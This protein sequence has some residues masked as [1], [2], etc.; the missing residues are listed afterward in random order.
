MVNPPDFYASLAESAL[1]RAAPRDVDPGIKAN[2]SEMARTWA[3]L[4]V[5]SA[6]DRLAKA[7]ETGLT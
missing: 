4:A 3:L 2:E 5:A 1:N 7:T 6:I